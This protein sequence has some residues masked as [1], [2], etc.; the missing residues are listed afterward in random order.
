MQEISKKNEKILPRELPRHSYEVIKL[1]PTPKG[2]CDQ[3]LGAKRQKV[4][5]SIT[6]QADD[7]RSKLDAKYPCFKKT[8]VKSHVSGCFWMGLPQRF[9]RLHL[10]SVDTYFILEIKTGKQYKAK[11][12]AQRT[13]LSGGWREFSL[14][15]KLSEGDVLVFQLVN[16]TKFKVFRIR[17]GG[18]SEVHGDH[19]KLNPV[20][21][22]E[23]SG[24]KGLE[25]NKETHQAFSPKAVSGD[26]D[27]G[28]ILSKENDGIV[29]KAEHVRKITLESNSS[30]RK[31]PQYPPFVGN[32]NGITTFDDFSLEQNEETRRVSSPEEVSPDED[33]AAVISED[34]EIV[35]KAGN[36][37][38][39]TS[40]SYSGDPK[41]PLYPPITGDYSRIT[42]F[43]DFIIVIEELL[44]K[45]YTLP[46]HIKWSY[47]QLC[48]SQKSFLHANLLKDVNPILV[49]GCIIETVDIANA[50]K[51]C[52]LPTFD[53]NFAQWDRKLK[54][55]D[56]LGMNVRFL[57][58][59]LLHLQRI[60]CNSEAAM[61][62]QKYMN[63]CAEHADSENIIK[64]IQ[65]KLTE[66][67]RVSEKH[68]VAI[69][70]MKTEID[71]HELTFREQVSAPW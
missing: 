10:P 22:K 47:Y 4:M 46:Y 24:V 28:V 68:A 16:P 5:P 44:K 65:E 39:I 34:D 17:K 15:E 57:L 27:H 8:L 63:L 18:L 25:Q 1:P 35:Q 33:H 58:A 41:H 56:L 45:E 60:A 32:H 49:A 31:H 12:L 61:K 62:R 30:D 14:A 21:K 59:R 19:A 67:R 43:D 64:S 7:S 3:Q 50:M 23:Q 20:D 71:E 69:D 38:E 42:T 37:K 11:Y 13:A 40:E 55:L 53:N 54:C 70:K 9:C 26:E 48:F 36:I 2:I 52:E 6:S 66:L 29:W 51:S